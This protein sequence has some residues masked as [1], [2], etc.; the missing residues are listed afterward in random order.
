MKNRKKI[1][2]NKI[3]FFRK[4]QFW[5]RRELSAREDE[6]YFSEDDDDIFKDE[7]IIKNL[8]TITS[9]YADNKNTDLNQQIQN[10]SEQINSDKF[11]Q[12]NLNIM[13]HENLIT[14]SKNINMEIDCERNMKYIDKCVKNNEDEEIQLLKRKKFPEDNQNENEDIIG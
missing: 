9:K 4:Y 3:K 10:D 2:L 11:G 8:E 5:N 12:S 14:S 6:D 7:Q 1:K 13:D